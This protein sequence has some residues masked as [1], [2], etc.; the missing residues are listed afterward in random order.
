MP[1]AAFIWTKAG[2]ELEIGL[3]EPEH[4]AASRFAF[5][6]MFEIPK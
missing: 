5:S 3:G 2:L 4:L 6:A 1:G